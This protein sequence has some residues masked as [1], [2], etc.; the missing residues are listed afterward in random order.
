MHAHPH[1][2]LACAVLALTLCLPLTPA[3]GAPSLTSPRA[4]EAQSV[5]VEV[6]QATPSIT[7]DGSLR[8]NVVVTLAAPAEYVEVRL[9]L[10]G[11]S[12]TLLYQKTEVRSDLPAGRHAIV[13]DHDMTRLGLKQGRYP[14]EVRVL[15]SGA[16]QTNVTDRLLVVDTTKEPLPIALVVGVT[17]TPSVGIDGRFVI[18][19]AEDTGVRDTVAF[20]TQLALDR[21]QHL[22]LAIAPVLTEQ[23]ARAAAGYE[24]T[25][26]VVAGADAEVPTRYT[27]TLADL[28]SAVASGAVDMLDV[29]YALPDLSGLER[30]GRPTDLAAHWRRADSANAVALQSSTTSST[31]YIGPLLTAEALATIG[32]RA[33]PAL[34]TSRAALSGAGGPSA[35]GCYTIAGSD[36]TV[37]VTDDDVAAAVVHGADAFYD[38]A[39]DR[40]QDRGCVVVMLNVG[41]SGPHAVTDVQ[42]ALDWIAAVPWLTSTPVGSIRGST[43]H[44]TVTDVDPSTDPRWETIGTARTAAEAYMAAAGSDNAAARTVRDA[45][46]VAE[47]ALWAANDTLGARSADLASRATDFVVSEFDRV[48]IDAKDVTLS[49]RRGSVPFTLVN[50]TGKPLELTL[51]ASA[52]DLLVRKPKI[53]LTAQP[54]DNFITVPVDLRSVIRDDLKVTVRAGEMTV[55]E[56]FVTVRASYL[57]NIATIAIVLVVLIGLLLFIK[58]RVNAA[59]A[60]SIAN[61]DGPEDV[62]PTH[63]T[64]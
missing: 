11:T 40:L 37:I 62:G 59:F 27:R 22:A 14:I 1:R 63:P 16:T 29:P 24:T 57:D 30:I 43:A 23:L 7:P 36:T 17:G 56:S 46:L 60:G 58:R 50:G 9:R 44:A 28:R 55:A 34:V 4:S 20:L 10:R 49:G 35:P 6:A 31:A 19:P 51:E 64:E 21:R 52:R 2:R 48:T 18:D 25:A 47:S 41:S 39:F 12:G 42:H 3:H 8:A 54:D 53:A 45:T 32:E 38:A 61:S 15:A 26:G 33:A 13:Y 5:T